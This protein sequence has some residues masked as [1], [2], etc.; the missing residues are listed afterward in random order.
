MDRKVL[1]MFNKI[2]IY[3]YKQETKIVKMRFDNINYL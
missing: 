2:Y 1:R 3:S